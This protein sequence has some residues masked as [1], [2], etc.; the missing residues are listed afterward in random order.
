MESMLVKH[1]LTLTMDR[2]SSIRRRV[3]EIEDVVRD[4]SEGGYSQPQVIPVPDELDP[5]IPRMILSSRAG[6]SQILISQLAIT[7]NANYSPDWASSPSKCLEYLLS[8]IEMLFKIAHVGWDGAQ[9]RFSG[10]V[11]TFQVNTESASQ[12]VAIVAPSFTDSEGLLKEAGEV[13]YRWSLA[14]G[15]QHYN[16]ISVSTLVRLRSAFQGSVDSIP[17]FNEKT[18]EGHGVEVSGDFNDRLAYNVQSSYESS[19][20]TARSLAIAGFEKTSEVV[21]SLLARSKA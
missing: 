10:V 4:Y 16:N 9:P 17:K 6:H 12:S 2:N 13:S 21:G 1:S 14:V 11:T 5:E 20:E 8:K 3:N 18:V 15:H 7:F 19:E